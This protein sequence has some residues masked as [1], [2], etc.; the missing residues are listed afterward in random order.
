MKLN[1]LLFL[2]VFFSV[3]LLTQSANAEK[4][5]DVMTYVKNNDLNDTYIAANLM[6]RCAGVTMGYAKYLPVDM[7]KTKKGFAEVG[8][9]LILKAG[10]ILY[11]RGRL[12]NKEL[13]SE[14]QNKSNE[15]TLKQNMIALEI[16]TK[17]Y[18][19]KIEKNQLATGLIFSGEVMEE[20]KICK[21]VI[22]AIK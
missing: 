20:L 10:M 4:V 1:N 12:H 21:S 7:Q 14:K 11:E 13:S 6:Q 3:V 8:K 22:N 16:Y 15:D 2:P 5:I 18:F 9:K 17:H 19:S